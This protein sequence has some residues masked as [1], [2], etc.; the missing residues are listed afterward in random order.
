MKIEFLYMKYDKQKNFIDGKKAEDVG[1]ITTYI[2]RE[3]HFHISMIDCPNQ[4]WMKLKNY[5]IRLMKVMPII[6]RKS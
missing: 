3:I 1:V 2:S 6:L 5:S 4:F